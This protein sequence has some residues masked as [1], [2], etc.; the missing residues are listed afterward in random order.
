MAINRCWQSNNISGPQETSA[1]WKTTFLT[2]KTY[3][4]KPLLSFSRHRPR[5][6][7]PR[8]ILE[9]LYMSI[10]LSVDWIINS[11]FIQFLKQT[12]CKC[13]I[14]SEEW[15]SL[16]RPSWTLW[17]LC[18]C[19]PLPW[20]D[21]TAYKSTR[22]H[23]HLWKKWPHTLSQWWIDKGIQAFPW[24]KKRKPPRSEVQVWKPS[25]PGVRGPDWGLTPARQ[26]KKI[27]TSLRE[28]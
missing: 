2:T 13:F 21:C 11:V 8:T 22:W 27:P 17:L 10:M 9:R 25:E 7:I 4:K 18:V 3:S 16:K 5:L 28:H 14:R 19:S 20:A 23:R 15:I 12:T 24:A 6:M 1:V 26:T